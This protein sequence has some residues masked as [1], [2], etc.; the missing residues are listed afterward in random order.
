MQPPKIKTTALL[1]LLFLASTHAANI[2]IAVGQGGLLFTPNTSTAAAGDKLTFH[3]YNLNGN[4]IPHNVIQGTFDSPCQPM[5]GGFFSGTVTTQGTDSVSRMSFVVEVKGD[6]PVWFYCGIGRHCQNGM[7]GV[8][9]A[10]SDS[11]LSSYATSARSVPSSNTPSTGPA[12]GIILDANNPASSSAPPESITS[13]PVSDT[14]PTASVSDSESA[15]TPPDT[16]STTT[17][18]IPNSESTG[19]MGHG[20]GTGGGGMNTGTGMV[21]NSTGAAAGVRV[22]GARQ[23]GAVG[24]GMLEAVGGLVG[25][26]VMAVGVF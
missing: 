23:T 1:P 4:T 26:G 15:S 10:P 13:S 2:D 7:V 14:S 24:V 8:V 25:L 6:G 9:N 20:N 11:P 19:A 12:G 21:T 5:D 3:F 17:T 22:P 18:T 16:D